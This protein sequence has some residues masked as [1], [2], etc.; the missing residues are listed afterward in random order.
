MLHSPRTPLTREVLRECMQACASVRCGRQRACVALRRVHRAVLD[1]WLCLRSSSQQKRLACRH[2][3][4]EEGCKGLR[5]AH[6]VSDVN[7][8]QRLVGA[9]A[10][11]QA[12]RHNFRLN[13]T[14]LHFYCFDSGTGLQI[15]RNLAAR[16]ATHSSY[17]VTTH[18]PPSPSPPPSQN[19][20]GFDHLIPILLVVDEEPRRVCVHCPPPPP[21]LHPL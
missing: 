19:A 20:A 10:L 8:Y 9:L 14:N 12:I 17:I 5:D 1:R 3:C 13:E 16:A 11:P 4:T 6:L 7:Y 21:P 15:T 18:T 2:A